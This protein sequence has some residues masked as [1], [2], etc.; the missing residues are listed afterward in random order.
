[1]G[2]CYVHFAFVFTLI[3]K[4][5]LDPSVP[6]NYRLV[7]ISSSLSKIIELYI[8]QV[9]GEHKLSDLQFGFVTGRGTDIAV[10]LASDVIGYCTKRGLP[11]YTC[12]L[13][14]EGVFDAIPHNVLFYKAIDV[15]P[16]HCW[17]IVVNWYKT[18]YVQCGVMDV[19]TRFVRG[20]DERVHT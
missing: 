15:L 5:T 17:R 12:S 18:M 11:V 3:K 14:A 2:H 16:D 9:S 4:P 7:T 10:S 6:A 19:N 13:D 20:G 1:M 8:L